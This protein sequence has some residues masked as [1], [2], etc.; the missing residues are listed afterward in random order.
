MSKLV[1]QIRPYNPVIDQLVV[2]GDGNNY[3][4]VTTMSVTGTFTVATYDPTDFTLDDWNRIINLV[5]YRMN[6]E[7]SCLWVYCYSR[8]IL[9]YCRREKDRTHVLTLLVIYIQEDLR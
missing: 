1:I 7:V 6:L 3:Q 9:I 8:L 5:E 2:R 4:L